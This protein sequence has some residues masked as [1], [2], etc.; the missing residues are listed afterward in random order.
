MEQRLV[1]EKSF[2]NIGLKNMAAVCGIETTNR[3]KAVTRASRFKRTYLTEADVKMFC[4]LHFMV[5]AGTGTARFVI[6]K[7]LASMI[8]VHR[9]TVVSCYKRLSHMGLIQF[10]PADGTSLDIV[11]ITIVRYSDMFQKRGD[12]GNGYFTMTSDFLNKVLCA[13][14]I[15]ELRVL[16]RLTA[17]TATDELF[18]T[19]KEPVSI[20]S[21]DELRKGLPKHMKPGVI[22]RALNSVGDVFDVV[23]IVGKRLLI[24]LKDDYRGSIIKKHIH[25]D[26]RIAIET[27]TRD[28]STII[29]D[30][31]A[32]IRRVTG[33]Y[34][35]R[36][37]AFM[38]SEDIQNRF[39]CLGVDLPFDKYTYTRSDYESRKL[40]IAE[41]IEKGHFFEEFPPELPLIPSLALSSTDINDCCLLAHDY[42]IG[43]VL[44]ILKSYYSIYV[45][46]DCAL[47]ADNRSIGGL[48]RSM[49]RENSARHAFV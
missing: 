4:L 14:G 33:F 8:D 39:K 9:K 7:D 46:G 37:T 48:L 43:A 17:S 28:L 45:A 32:E 23:N 35:F 29:F 5:N 42:G 13:K 25:L 47:P 2:A 44:D 24:S 1:L 10:A 30:A 40:W 15:E 31:N 20:L 3:R 38:P 11:H 41:E 49:L 18:Q 12:G 34:F 36:H 27:F 16:L 21:M 22:R 19:T 26:T 6:T